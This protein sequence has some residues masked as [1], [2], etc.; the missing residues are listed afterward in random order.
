[1]HR[2]YVHQRIAL[3]NIKGVFIDGVSNDKYSFFIKARPYQRL[4]NCSNV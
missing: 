2:L 4:V 1:M 3:M